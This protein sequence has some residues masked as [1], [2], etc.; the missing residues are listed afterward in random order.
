MNTV[1][2]QETLIKLVEEN[3]DHQWLEAF[4]ELRNGNSLPG[5]G[6]MSLNDWGPNY[7]GIKKDI[8]YSNL[9][10]VLRKVIKTSNIDEELKSFKF[11]SIHFKKYLR[12][13]PVCGLFHCHP[14]TIEESISIEFLSKMIPNYLGSNKLQELLDPSNSFNSDEVNFFRTEL[15]YHLSRKGILPHNFLREIVLC[16]HCEQDDHEPKSDKYLIL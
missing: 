15:H 6:A 5:G 8:W 2:F 4:F 11:N 7:I 16:P 1:Q 12:E 9:Y 3:Q 10:D 13:C 14:K